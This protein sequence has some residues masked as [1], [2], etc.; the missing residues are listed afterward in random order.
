MEN[1]SGDP[2]LWTAFKKGDENAFS[3]IYQ[4]YIKVLYRYG[5]KVSNDTKIV[6]DAIQDLF[7][8]IWNGRE[9]LT[10][11]D[12]VKYYLLRILRRKINRNLE[13]PGLMEPIEDQN[14]DQIFNTES[15]ESEIVRTEGNDQTSREIQD[16]IL[17]LSLRQQ[18]AINL[19]YFHSFTH[20][21]IA[22]IMDISL[23]SVHNTLQ[24]AMKGLREILNNYPGTLLFIYIFNRAAG[25][26]LTAIS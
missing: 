5:H 3:Q 9:N 18:E 4:R 2:E 10:D 15:F 26:W 1:S 21:Q 24:K 11:P 14:L 22:E 19:R 20:N 8:D 25:A 16:A 6:E 13:Y 12:S 23:Q 7:V 17:Q